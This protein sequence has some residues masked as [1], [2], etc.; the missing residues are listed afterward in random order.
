LSTFQDGVFLGSAKALHRSSLLSATP[1]K[2]G[3]KLTPFCATQL[4][5][6]PSPTTEIR[7]SRLLM[8]RWLYA[9]I[10]ATPRSRSKALEGDFLVDRSRGPDLSSRQCA[11]AAKRLKELLQR[12]C[13]SPI[14]RRPGI[15]LLPG[16]A[17]PQ[18]AEENLRWEPGA[19]RCSPQL[20][21]GPDACAYCPAQA[22]S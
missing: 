18:R 9:L 15:R 6:C 5:T 10:V 16:N 14:A 1:Q 4:Y 13:V 21:E 3:C 17:W 2:G 8:L 22:G 20:G 7:T 11:G 12:F 19:V